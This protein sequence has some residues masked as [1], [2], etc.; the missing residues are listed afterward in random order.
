[1]RVNKLFKALPFALFIILA[2]L[3][4]SFHP[5]VMQSD[6]K[7]LIHT[8]GR[9]DLTYCVNYLKSVT[10]LKPSDF[11]P[12]PWTMTPEFSGKA[13]GVISPGAVLEGQLFRL[14][15]T[16]ISFYHDNYSRR[17]FDME[18]GDVYLMLDDL[19][20]FSGQNPFVLVEIEGS[21][22]PCEDDVA[23]TR[24]SLLEGVRYPIKVSEIAYRL[25]PLWNGIEGDYREL[26]EPIAENLT[27]E[28]YNQIDT[29]VHVTWFNDSKTLQIVFSKMAYY[30]GPLEWYVPPAYLLMA[31][32][33]VDQSGRLMESI[34]LVPGVSLEIISEHNLS[35]MNTLT[36]P[37]VEMFPPLII[38][39]GLYLGL[40]LVA[41]DHVDIQMTVDSLNATGK[42]VK[43]NIYRI[44]FI[45]SLIL[46]LYGLVMIASDFFYVYRY[47]K[48][49]TSD[50]WLWVFF[51]VAMG[52]ALL[53]IGVLIFK[54]IKNLRKKME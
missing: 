44:L 27:R 14:L 10:R 31:V 42:G 18:P 53:Y 24:I 50:G 43:K 1:M 49:L 23:V 4:G 52:L 3:L 33:R 29:F 9:Q 11:L 25:I 2:M 15:D 40:R 37:Y 51:R 41:G 45:I 47:F 46:A 7:T 19:P 32:F 30:M 20:C 28:M 34:T 35:L 22:G 21:R 17:L 38:G 16:S 26:Y 12:N 54:T 36:V 5:L 13:E 8:S 6:L 39:L 48:I